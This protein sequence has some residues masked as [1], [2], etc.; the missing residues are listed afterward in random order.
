MKLIIGSLSGAVF[1]PS[2]SCYDTES[3]KVIAKID[4]SGDSDDL[5][6]DSKAPSHLRDLRRWKDRHQSSKWMQAPTKLLNQNR[7]GERRSHRAFVPERD[8]LFVAVPHR[9]SQQAEIR[10][11]PDRIIL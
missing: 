11:L 4:I 9:G 1:H 7:H 8:S 2:S 6:Y 5:F 10:R 3:G